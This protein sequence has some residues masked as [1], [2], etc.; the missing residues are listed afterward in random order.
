[1][2]KVKKIFQPLTSEGICLVYESLLARGLVSF[3]ITKVSIH[4]IE[5][6]ISSVNGSYFGQEIYETTE[7][8]VVAYLYFLIKNHPFTDGNKRTA[9]I[10]FSLSSEIN[11]LEV[12]EV[13]YPLDA[14]AVF[15]EQIQETN[16][17]M[18]IKIIADSIFKDKK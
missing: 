6:I 9:I 13:D 18:V 15:I 5:A 16:H 4:K 2:T 7:E 17:Q 14:L 10:S 1:M 8:K 12:N 11:N 3:P